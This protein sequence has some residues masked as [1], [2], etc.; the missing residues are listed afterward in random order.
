MGFAILALCIVLAR[1]SV[2]DDQV[3]SLDDDL[4]QV[5]EGLHSLVGARNSTDSGNSTE[6]APSTPKSAELVA[7][8]ARVRETLKKEGKDVDES[9]IEQ[10]ARNL[11]IVDEAERDTPRMREIED[12]LEK[13]GPK[14][15]HVQV[16]PQQFVN[17]EAERDAQE[18]A[19]KNEEAAQARKAENEAKFRAQEKE[20]ADQMLAKYA[21]ET[22][23]PKLQ[24]EID[25]AHREWRNAVE[26]DKGLKPDDDGHDEYGVHDQSK[27]GPPTA[28]SNT[29]QQATAAAAPRPAPAASPPA[30]S[31]P[32]SSAPAASTPAQAPPSL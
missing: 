31:T 27:W 15:L 14:E 16:D 8:I 21:K 26:H 25:T 10:T 29:A 20:R 23:N 18:A 17:E 2:V 4:A 6:P 9:T 1:A 28:A 13:D 3:V 30:A 19:K 7:Y 22:F 24:N 32:A 5:G 12:S 11:M